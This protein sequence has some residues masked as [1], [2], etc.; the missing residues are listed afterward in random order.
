MKENNIALIPEDHPIHEIW[1]L[2]RLDL[3]G[4][5]ELAKTGDVD[6]AKT[7]MAQYVYRKD[8]ERIDKESGIKRIRRNEPDI[9]EDYITEAIQL[10]Y[11][12]GNANVG[13]NLEHKNSHRPKSTYKEKRKQCDIAYFV[14]DIIEELPSDSKAYYIASK[15]LYI[16]TGKARHYFEMYFRNWKRN[17][18]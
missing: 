11:I 14:A 2:N 8:I 15:K 1:K 16:S 13:F 5:I 17:R 4:L 7:L 6:A 3:K 10:A 9:L 18:K 12:V